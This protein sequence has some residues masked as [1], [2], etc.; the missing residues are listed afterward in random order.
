RLDD[1]EDSR[2]R[3][4]S[5]SDEPHIA[6]INL[7]RGHLR[8][9]ND[10]GVHSAVKVPP[11]EPNQRDQDKVGKNAASAENHGTAQTH[12]IAETEDEAD[13]IEIEHHPG[14][15]GNSTHDGNELKVHKLFPD[16]KRGY[17]EVVD[18]RDG[19]GLEQQ[20]G[21][22]SAFLPSDQ[23]FSDGGRLRIG[24]HAVHFAHEVPAQRN[25]EQ[26]TEAPAC[27]TDED[28]LHRMR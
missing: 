8:N 5:H 3:D 27:Q 16:L 4:G 23:Y 7:H 11:D 28:G 15:V 9:G 24:Q 26:N 17:K 19:G 22:R 1:A 25:Q 20:P 10:G 14:T 2:R 12:H 18:T 21:L 13:G 6:T